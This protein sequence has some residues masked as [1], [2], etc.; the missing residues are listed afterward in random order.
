MQAT[1][2]EWDTCANST[3]VMNPF[4]QWRFLHALETSDCASA[5]EGWQPF[6]VLVREE[7][8]RKLLACCPNYIK[9]KSSLG[10]GLGASVHVRGQHP[11]HIFW[12]FGQQA[13]QTAS[14]LLAADVRL[15]MWVR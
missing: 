1:E 3:G 9:S 2:E 12:L 5:Y 6:H 13:V 15:H 4:V 11:S 7:G 14:L 10:R 8:T